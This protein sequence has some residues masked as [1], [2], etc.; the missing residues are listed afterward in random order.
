MADTTT[1]N[2]DDEENGRVNS[3]TA[4]AQNSNS[5]PTTITATNTIAG[6]ASTTT[7]NGYYGNKVGFLQTFSLV[8]NA[9]L[10]IYAHVGLSAKVFS[11]QPP[12]TEE[13]TAPIAND[14][15][16]FNF[17]TF[18][19]ISTNSTDADGEVIQLTG[20]CN[21]DD[22]NIWINESGQINRT[23]HSDFCSRRYETGGCF[24]DSTCVSECFHLTYGYTEGCATCFGP[25]PSCSFNSGC[26]PIC[27]ADSFS[28]A[29][30]DCNE[31]C[32]A[33]METCLGFPESNTEED[34]DT[35][36]RGRERHRQ[37]QEGE[38]LN[39]DQDSLTWYSVFDLTFVNSIERA[40]NGNARFLA[41]IIIVFSGIWPYAKNVV[42]V[43]AWYYPMTVEG[44][45]SV[46]TWLLRLSKYTLVDVFALVSVLVG[47]LLELN[48]GGTEVATR[49]E[50]RPAI[51][52]FFFATVWEFV[53]IEWV[54]RCHNRYLKDLETKDG[55]AQ[56]EEESTSSGHLLDAM[57]F[58]TQLFSNDSK[59]ALAPKE[60]T[61]GLRIWV[62]VLLIA[63]IGVYLAGATME[64][65]RFTSFGAGDTIGCKRAY[66]LATF[67]NAIV[68]DLSLDPSSAAPATWTLYIAYVV[69]VLV[70]PIAVHCLQILILFL[71]SMG[72]QYDETNRVLCHWTS[73]LWGFASVEVLLIGIY[74]VEAEF[75]KFVEALAGDENAEFFSIQSDLGPAFYL[76]II[77]SIL[78]GLLQY[79]IYCATA[80]YY[81]VDPYHKVHVIWT[82]L[83][84]CFLESKNL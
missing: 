13:D 15:A 35:S 84:T 72:K 24:I 44:R 65:A 23:A 2:D 81:H 36:T 77:Y 70:L 32:V 60:N 7:L 83:L 38:C 74:A 22:Y 27:A 31:D 30:R 39:L 71:A 37:L 79:F 73:S 5:K 80:E 40:W 66:N 76:L 69:L 48:V 50:P 34:S 10:M 1:H 19:P 45:T 18:P 28:I 46:L 51:L 12:L 75:E 59:T 26:A 68:S 21:L 57:R 62:F 9:G 4:V 63:T 33:T 6:T 55:D 58:R 42:L 11:S 25:V 49:A 16:A 78:S 41:I 43:W 67:G 29:C 56:V 64:I 47:V 8:L 3:S 17:T 52:A 54:V 61:R 82:K 20:R 53:Q 14:D